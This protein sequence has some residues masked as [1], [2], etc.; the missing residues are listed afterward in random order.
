MD[1][2]Q[3]LID[4]V[5]GRFDGG[6]FAERLARLVAVRSTSQ[7]PDL[8]P[9]S[10]RYLDEELGP[11]LREMGF[12][13]EAFPNPSAGFGPILVAERIEGADLPTVVTYGHGDT[14]RGMDAD[15]THGAGPWELRREGDRW[16]GRGSA[17]NKGQH[18]VSLFALEAA[19]AHRSGRLGFNVK[20]VLEMAEERGSA[21]LR[22]FVAAHAGRLRGDVFVASD[23]PRAAP[24]APTVAA[25]SR[26][27]FRLDLVV[28]PRTGGV[29][30]GHWGGLTTDP[31]VVL[32]HALAA[33]CDRH[34]R[35]LVRDWLPAASG[36]DLDPA[37]RALLAD[38]PVDG[39]TEAARV[40]P[41]WGEPG[42]TPAER[43]Y[44][45]N[46]FIVLATVSG[47]PADPVNAVSPDARATCEIRYVPGTPPDGFMPALRRHLDAAGFGEVEI[48]DAHVRMPA[49]SV[50]PTSPW[51]AWAA[52][53][54]GRTLGT[55]PQVIPCTSGGMPGD[56]F[57]DLLG[58]PLVWVPHGHNGCRQ[59]G[60]DEHLL[61]PVA[62]EGVAMMA[63]LWWDFGEGGLPTSDAAPPGGPR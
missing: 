3:G 36:A 13:T 21:G 63:G 59:H 46:A 2:R 19:L 30:S 34:G 8:A 22:E 52:R 49:S 17:D 14:V 58:V 29:H 42:L 26:G 23:G 32:A 61:V 37:V 28:A 40:E 5:R 7:E 33:I 39:G 50:D 6:A 24:S 35:I 47:R 18:L 11:W 10:R 27:N 56:V 12:E 55:P 9:E 44:A 16:Y 60:P 15:W 31:A 53:S 25:G 38:C 1:G 57:Q 41:G 48:R 20:L 43:L 62:R 4:D 45:W 54:V 51:I